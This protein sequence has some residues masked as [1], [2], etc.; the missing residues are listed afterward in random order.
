M[1]EKVVI[2]GAGS[3][4]FT[5]GLVAD[6]IERGWDL[7]LGLVDIDERALETAE[8]LSRKM[9]EARKA[10]IRLSAS[11]D[12]REVL[13]GATAV[14]TTIAVGGRRGWEMDVRIPRRYGI[15]Q[16]V[17]DSVM[18]G[19]SSRALRMIPPM[20]AIAKDV[21]ELALGAL[22]FN[23]ANPMSVV[24]R[25]VR[26]ETGAGMVG[27]CH[28]VVHVGRYLAELLGA[29]DS[30]VSYTAV[31][32]NHL[33]WFTEVR[34]K[35]KDAKPRLR[36]IAH[37]KLASLSG[38]K[39]TVGQ[40]LAPAQQRPGG[41]DLVEIQPFT[42]ELFLLFDAF[43]AVLDRHVT[44]FFPYLFR[45]KG[46]YYGKTLGVDAYS[47]EQ[48]IQSGDRIYAEMQ[49]LAFSPQPL[50]EDYFRRIGGE[51]EQVV[52]IIDSIRTDAGRVYSANLPN[53]GQAPNLPADG[54]VE[55][56]A[57]ADASGMHPVSL[58]PLSPGLAGTLA[59]RFQW[60]ETLVE[61]AV[62]GSREKFI[63]AL[64]LD[65]AVDSVATAARLAE[66]LLAAH[67]QH[68]PQFNGRGPA[69]P[70]RRDR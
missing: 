47:M 6:L 66:D 64:V 5:R 58:E 45:G 49:E 18:P 43:P 32:M 30:D 10:P 59:T 28:G 22:F 11:T 14:I 1:R 31:G 15:Y 68:L 46:S 23:Y 21:V 52:D 17:G 36:E 2:I 12:R 61:A 33:T 9:V 69:S 26:K 7:E 35:G 27:L 42:W 38:A 19:G 65:G 29:A 34:V 62:E 57:I 13:K 39:S 48:T 37:E 51:H 53:R 60:V 55:S 40:E 44:E 56:P 41:V 67:A 24:C 16:P 3:A 20:V 70:R 50:G 54:I 63:Q 4:M 25:A 8:R